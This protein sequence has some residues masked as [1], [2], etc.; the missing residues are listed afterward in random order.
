MYK[1]DQGGPVLSG[2]GIF[3]HGGTDPEQKRTSVHR[4]NCIY[5]PD[6][7]LC[8]SC[9]QRLQFQLSKGLFLYR[10]WHGGFRPAVFSQ[11]YFCAAAR[12][13]DRK[14]HGAQ[15]TSVHGA[16][17]RP[18]RWRKDRRRIYG[19]FYQ[20]GYQDRRIDGFCKKIT[21]IFFPTRFFSLISSGF[22]IYINGT[23][24]LSS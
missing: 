10:L 20:S 16:C 6:V 4:S 2:R 15:A 9:H 5:I 17:W 19:F 22:Y 24:F 13:A 1:S 11:Y 7:L 23:K 8:H 3:L 18:V 12:K 21:I 14:T